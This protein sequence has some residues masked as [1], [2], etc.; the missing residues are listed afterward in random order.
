MTDSITRD[1]TIS[2]P[3]S[4]VWR[5]LSDHE[6]FGAWFGVAI[7]GPF[8]EGTTVRGAYTKAGCEHLVFMARVTAVQPERYFAYEWPSYT[9]EDGQM[10]D[11]AWTQVEFRLEPLGEA[12]RVTVQE[13]GFDRLP[14][15][16][17]ARALLGNTRG[18]EAQAR[19]LVRSIEAEV[20][21]AV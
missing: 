11:E 8:R 18:W 3:L 16:V 10:V 20:V 9:P 17:R 21:D 5:S 6:A 15:G 14:E 13:S 2:A 4:R 12:T 1:I 19:N 7:D